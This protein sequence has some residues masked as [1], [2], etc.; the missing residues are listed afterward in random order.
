MWALVGSNRRPPPCEEASRQ[1]RYPVKNASGQVRVTSAIRMNC[2]CFQLLDV[3]EQ[4]RDRPGRQRLRPRLHGQAEA[5]PV[6]RARGYDQRSSVGAECHRVPGPWR[7]AFPLD[8]PRPDRAKAV[9]GCEACAT[10]P[11]TTEYKRIGSLVRR[12]SRVPEHSF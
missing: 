2:G 12:G 9:R 11:K 4:E 8:D 3:G 1:A 10:G 6:F 7:L 5:Y